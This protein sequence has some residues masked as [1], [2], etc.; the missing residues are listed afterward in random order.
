MSSGKPIRIDFSS[1]RGNFPGEATFEKWELLSPMHISRSE[2][3]GLQKRLGGFSE[4]SCDMTRK[5]CVT[6]G[7]VMQA[8]LERVN[9]SVVDEEESRC[10]EGSSV[11]YFFAGC[12]R[13]DK[14]DE[15]IL[16]TL[17]C[18]YFQCPRNSFEICLHLFL[19]CH[20]QNYV[21]Q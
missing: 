21:Q 11:F 17:S 4:N 15:K 10:G 19:I 18:R 13:R 2:F 8:V 16:I 6:P 12:Y 20:V 9:V 1:D 5:S 3:G 7:A 14:I